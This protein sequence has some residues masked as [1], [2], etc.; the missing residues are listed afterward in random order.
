MAHTDP[1]WNQEYWRIRS[2]DTVGLNVDSGWA[3]DE[4][5]G[6]TI[7]TGQLF[8]IRF[9]VRDSTGDYAV[10][11][12]VKLQVN[13]GA[14]W[15][16]ADI[17]DGSAT[18]AILVLDSAQYTH[19]D[20]TSTELLTSTTTYVNG[21]GLDTSITS[22][23]V[24]AGNSQETEFE[25][26]MMAMGFY[27]GPSQNQDS[28]TLTFRL[29]ESGGTVF[30]GTYN[31]PTITISETAGYI[32]GTHVETPGRI[33]PFC[34]G[35]GNLYY[36]IENAETDNNFVMIKSTDG[37]D[38][39]REVDGSNRPTETDLESVDAVQRGTAIYI[40]HHSGSNV[41]HH[42]FNTSDAVSNPDTWVTTDETVHGSISYYD[43]FCAI[44]RR[45]FG[46]YAG[47]L[48]AFYH[49]DDAGDERIS[50]KVK[51]NGGSWGSEQNLDS[52]AS[53]DFRGVMCVKE[54]GSDKI[55]ICY[56]DATNLDIFH[57]SLDDDGTLSARET[58]TTDSP[59]SPTGNCG[60]TEMIAWL[61][62]SDEKAMVCY[63]DHSESKLKSRVITND[64]SPATEAAA[65]DNTVAQ[66]QG[67]SRQPVASLALYGTTALLLYADNTTRDLYRDEN[68]NDGGWG[69]DAEETDGLD[70]DYIRGMVFTHSAGN[71]GDTVLGYVYEDGGSGHTGFI[72]YAERVLAG[73]AEPFP[74]VPGR[75]HRDHRSPL[76]RM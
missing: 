15:V 4:N 35:N 26:C 52:T 59:I 65:S 37:G 5:I 10:S 62:G 48:V 20:A 18:P 23:S 33:G 17:F 42:L 73:P 30:G 44:E 39:W 68:A 1:T 28:D 36:I 51:P 49:R 34:D 45:E 6:A 55:H 41:V 21:E 12:A 76:I 66:D 43:Q 22:G 50:Y 53:T 14:G 3:A 60:M 56:K 7:G 61:D 72:W 11:V 70:L 38:T 19:G 16:D 40:L 9:K 47:D 69:T 29:V 57:K 46:A 27:D 64:G 63:V 2:G 25:Y 8:R 24:A 67:T 54:A 58:I 32:G 75:I 31:N 13:D 74:P 71:G